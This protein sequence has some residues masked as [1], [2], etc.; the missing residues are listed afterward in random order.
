MHWFGFSEVFPKQ[1]DVTKNKCYFVFPFFQHFCFSKYLPHVCYCI[2]V[3]HRWICALI[4]ISV[5][6]GVVFF[7]SFSSL[8]LLS[9]PNMF[10]THF[11]C[12]S[13]SL[14]SYIGYISIDMMLVLC[15]DDTQTPWC[16]ALANSWQ[17]FYRRSNSNSSV[18]WLS[19]LRE[20]T[21]ESL[22]SVSFFFLGIFCS[23]TANKSWL[24][25][26]RS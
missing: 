11:F 17:V 19:S 18:L 25:S 23:L 6:P 9:C 3:F 2:P 10:D 13:R 16:C 7:C 22:G 21:D 12:M 14:K 4:S 20:I 8:V 5:Y 15:C 1:K 26:W 24:N